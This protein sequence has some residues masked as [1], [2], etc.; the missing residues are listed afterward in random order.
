M[1][2]AVYVHTYVCA[3][4]G[5]YR[6]HAC[7]IYTCQPTVYRLCPH[8]LYYCVYCRSELDLI[9]EQLAVQHARI[10]SLQ[11]D[12]T[13]EETFCQERLAEQQLRVRQVSSRQECGVVR[14]HTAYTNVLNMIGTLHMHKT[15]MHTHSQHICTYACTVPTYVF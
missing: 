5:T 10:L 12:N 1:F 2:Y 14:L 9:R 3:V 6:V 4:L 11:K 13:E 8:T 7:I 15:G